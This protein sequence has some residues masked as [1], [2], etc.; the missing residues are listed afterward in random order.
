MFDLRRAAGL[1]CMAPVDRHGRAV[2]EQP[3][4]VRENVPPLA[5]DSL[6]AEAVG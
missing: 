3:E 6:P 1:V 4:H 2:E 5:M